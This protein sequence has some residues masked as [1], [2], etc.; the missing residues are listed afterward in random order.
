MVNDEAVDKALEFVAKGGGNY[1]YLFGKLNSPDWI[2]PLQKRGRFSHPP[3]AIVEE[4]SIQ[5]PR[6]PEGEYLV[7][8]A[9]LAP[10]LVFSAI[11]VKVY[12]SDNHYVHQTLLQIA[13]ELPVS[14][15]AQVALAEAKWASQQRR[16]LGLY[17]EKIVPVILN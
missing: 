10:D 13:A 7:R 17:E 3:S 6:W 9:P 16:L 14:L 4:T 8:M 15:A 1:Q 2:P 5:F 11:D 12:E